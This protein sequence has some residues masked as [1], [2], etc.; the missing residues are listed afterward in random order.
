MIFRYMIHYVENV[1]ASMTFYERAFGLQR[2]FLHESGDYGE[3]V[4]GETKLAFSSRALIRSLGKDPAA[5]DPARPTHEIA[6][7]TADVAAA[8]AKAVDAGA[9]PVQAA[10]E[11]PWGQ[12]TS[13]VRDRDGYLVEICSPVQLPSPG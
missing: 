8:Y 6:F 11:E 7:E 3:L 9:I 1:E 5:P 2:G 4:T 13:Y 12:T 10:R